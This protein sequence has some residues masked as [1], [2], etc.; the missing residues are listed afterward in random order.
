MEYRRWFVSGRVQGVFFRESTRRKAISLAL[1]G[2]ARN[3]EDTRVEVAAAGP[4]ESLDELEA[5]LWQGPPLSKVSGVE[6]GPC[7]PEEI[8]VSL[9]GFTTR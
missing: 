6:G 3:L 9:D 5:W 2:Y 7:K 1:D 8:A 4:R